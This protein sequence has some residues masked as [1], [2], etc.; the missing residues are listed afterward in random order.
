MHA[1]TYVLDAPV[2]DA[3]AAVALAPLPTACP[4][5]GMGPLKEH[6]HAAAGGINVKA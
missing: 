1:C 2:L 5:I 6:S 3:P 4:C